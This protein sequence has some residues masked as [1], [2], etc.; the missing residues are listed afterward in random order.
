MAE[1]DP[2]VE[3]ANSVLAIISAL[4]VPAITVFRLISPLFRRRKK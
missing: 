1:D 3:K 2:A 4:L